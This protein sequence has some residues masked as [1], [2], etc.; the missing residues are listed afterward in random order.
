MSKKDKEVPF[1]WT[2]TAVD[3]QNILKLIDRTNIKG[4][5]AHVVSVIKHKLAA[6]I[7]P[8]KKEE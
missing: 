8:E 3:A 7:P 1:D 5:E 4:E 2:L 6:L